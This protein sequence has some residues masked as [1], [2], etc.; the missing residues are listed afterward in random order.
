MPAPDASGAKAHDLTTREAAKARDQEARAHDK[1]ERQAFEQAAQQIRDAVR[2]DPAL[3]DLARQL[4]ID[5]TPEGL[6]IQLLDEERSRCSP[7]A[8]RCSTS[9]RG[10]CC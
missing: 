6:R 5:Q 1:Q 2:A 10:R 4:A 3:A 7:P 8:R 9:A